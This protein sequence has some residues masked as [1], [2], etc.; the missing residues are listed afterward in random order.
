MRGQRHLCPNTTS[1]PASTKSRARRCI[2]VE[3][4]HFQ[5]GPLHTDLSRASHRVKPTGGL[6]TPTHSGLHAEGPQAS[7]SP[8]VGPHAPHGPA[9]NGTYACLHIHPLAHPPVDENDYQVSARFPRRRQLLPKH[10]GAVVFW[11]NEIDARPLVGGCPRR[12]VV[13]SWV[14]RCGGRDACRQETGA[15]QL[16]TPRHA[17]KV[18][19][20]GMADAERDAHAQRAL[21]PAA[22]PHCTQ[23][24]RRTA[25]H[26]A[27]QPC[28]TAQHPTHPRLHKRRRPGAGLLA[29]PGLAGPPP[30]HVPPQQTQCRQQPA[31]AAFQQAPPACN[32]GSGCSRGTQTA[33]GRPCGEG[34][35]CS[36]CEQSSMRQHAAV[37]CV[38]P[39]SSCRHELWNLQPSL[40]A[41]VLVNVSRERRQVAGVQLEVEGP[42]LILRD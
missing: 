17:A 18:C 30:L 27:Q 4:R 11:V 12:K 14:A 6:H 25:Q 8:Q 28:H 42:L 38:R 15:G 19:A 32:P 41:A 34:G 7:I 39:E 20:W 40:Q 26:P 24:A 10:R 37:M 5:L 21:N 3:G 31:L 29:P 33:G 16:E 23:H 35:A 1:A 2:A 36:S 9:S 13:W 22:T